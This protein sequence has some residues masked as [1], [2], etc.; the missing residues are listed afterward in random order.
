MSSPSFFSLY[1]SSSAP[2]AFSL[3][4]PGAQDHREAYERYQSPRQLYPFPAP[5]SKPKGIS[6]NSKP[7]LNARPKSPTKTR[8]RKENLKNEGDEN[9]VY[10]VQAGKAEKKMD[11]ARRAL[12]RITNR[13]RTQN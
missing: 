9:A 11:M 5:S 4:V 2:N 6:S 7:K 10:G 13:R 3:F 8:M 12:A 1:A